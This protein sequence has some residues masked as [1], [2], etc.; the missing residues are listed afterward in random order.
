MILQRCAAKNRQEDHPVS[1]VPLQDRYTFNYISNV[2][3]TTTKKTKNKT[4]SV[5]I[6]SILNNKANKQ[7][8][9]NQKNKV[10]HIKQQKKNIKK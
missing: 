8:K 2:Q 3:T 7:Y 5:K 4:S 10:T 1:H 6:K 9:F